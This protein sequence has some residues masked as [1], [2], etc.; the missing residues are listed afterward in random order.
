MKKSPQS[1]SEW[2]VG[3]KM[4]NHFAVVHGIIDERVHFFEDIS[5]MYCAQTDVNKSRV[6][7]P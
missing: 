2:L 5:I 7:L 3:Q 6:V 1:S 4:Q